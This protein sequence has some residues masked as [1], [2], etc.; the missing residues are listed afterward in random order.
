MF[1]LTMDLMAR[2]GF[3][4]YEVSNYARPGKESRHNLLYWR[5]APYVGVGPSAV[6]CYGGRR[7]RNVPDV[8]QYTRAI[9]DQ[10]NAESES[11]SLDV[12]K[13]MMEMVMMQ[14]RLNDGLDLTDFE[15]RTGRPAHNV[16][17]AGARRFLAMGIMEEVPGYWRL[18]RRGRPLA[19]HVIR[20]LVAT[21]DDGDVAL[22]VIL[23]Q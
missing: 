1:D 17:A 4:Q 9:D 10:G 23:S 16:F 3:I 5:N 20:E 8:G 2:E 22:P 6:G 15:R 14:L 13:L 12:S 18:T 21:I 19:E 11:E 7:Y